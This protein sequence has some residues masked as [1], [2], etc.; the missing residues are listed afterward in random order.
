MNKEENNEEI[1]STFS[2]YLDHVFYFGGMYHSISNPSSNNYN[3][4][5]THDFLSPSIFNG[6]TNYLSSF[7][8]LGCAICFSCCANC[9]STPNHF[10]R[11]LN[12]GTGSLTNS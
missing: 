10:S 7:N 9:L 8:H 3:F 5:C 2:P 4:C 11:T 6:E 12:L 1:A